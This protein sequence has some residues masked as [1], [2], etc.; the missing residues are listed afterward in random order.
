MP[1]EA[2]LNTLRGFL[3]RESHVELF[4]RAWPFVLPRAKGTSALRSLLI[5]ELGNE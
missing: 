2:A 3:R 1:S 4:L 5:S